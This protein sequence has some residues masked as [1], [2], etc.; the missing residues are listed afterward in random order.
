MIARIVIG[1]LLAY[2]LI[3]YYPLVLRGL[4]YFVMLALGIAAF[5]CLRAAP[6]LAEPLG[7]GILIVLLCYIVFLFLRQRNKLKEIINNTKQKKITLPVA[8]IKNHPQISLLLTLILYTL[9]LTFVFYLIILLI[10][11]K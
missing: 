1:V 10:Y 5:W 11:V 9:G 2:L 3:A 4:P 8:N 7:Y 6:E